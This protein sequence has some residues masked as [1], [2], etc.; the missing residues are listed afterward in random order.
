MSITK[1]A[2]RTRRTADARRRRRARSAPPHPRS[3]RVALFMTVASVDVPH[4][5]S[6]AELLHW[7][8]QSG[9]RMSGLVSGISAICAAILF[10]VVMNYLR[11]LTRHRRR[12]S[13]G[14]S[15]GR[16]ALRS[17]PSGW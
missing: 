7:W 8:Q 6:D 13:G 4:D 17:P 2:H 9:N 15:P 11:S 5:A 1:A 12:R 16:W 10:A 14:R 3:S